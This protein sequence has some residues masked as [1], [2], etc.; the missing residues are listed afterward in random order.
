M[1]NSYVIYFEIYE[2]ILIMVFTN[3]KL[4]KEKECK[5]YKKI[6]K[7]TR[8]DFDLLLKESFQLR[9]NIEFIIGQDK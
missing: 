7:K 6:I 8:K 9:K 5:K 2:I 4:D 3:I 1:N